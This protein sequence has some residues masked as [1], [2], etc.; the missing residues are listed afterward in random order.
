V[1]IIGLAMLALIDV[2]QPLAVKDE[3]QQRKLP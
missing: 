1:P 2:R 3:Q